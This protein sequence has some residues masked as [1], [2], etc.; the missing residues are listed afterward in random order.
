MRTLIIMAAIVLATTA[1]AKTYQ[2]GSTLTGVV[3]RV[4]DG[5]GLS[6]GNIRDI[7][8]QGIAAPEYSNVKQQAGGAES[9]A[10]LRAYVGG[11][12][13]T[14]TFDGTTAGRSKRP[15]AVCT[16]EGK[17]I[18]L[19]QVENGHARDCPNFSKGRYADAEAK[20]RAT[21]DLSA[22]YKLPSYCT[23]R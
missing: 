2:A 15:V 8:L 9:A 7:R 3:V 20:A 1:H 14:C 21:R 10:H 12:E 11:K 19:V 5:D 16:F 23:P 22:I 4:V 13:V 17:D 18:G 6:I